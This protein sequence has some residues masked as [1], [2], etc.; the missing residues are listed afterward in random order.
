MAQTEAINSSRAQVHAR[1]RPL[2]PGD[3]IVI[4]GISGKFPNSQNLEEFANN[5]YNKVNHFYCIY[6]SI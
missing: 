3:E 6:N 4:S 5:L 1:A 2:N